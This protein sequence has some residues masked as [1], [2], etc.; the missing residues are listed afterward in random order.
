M[1]KLL[2]NYLFCLIQTNYVKRLESLFIS[3]P[4]DK[5]KKKLLNAL[6]NYNDNAFNK[7]FF[8]YQMIKIIKDKLIC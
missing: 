4:T 3:L 5:I 2:P 6:F 7:T 8:A 1:F